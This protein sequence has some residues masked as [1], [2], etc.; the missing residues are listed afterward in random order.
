MAA[1]DGTIDH[2]ASPTLRRGPL[3]ALQRFVVRSRLRTISLRVWN[4]H[5]ASAGAPKR[6]ASSRR[7]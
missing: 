2:L 5:Q 6:A 3:S 7:I 1:F 4:H